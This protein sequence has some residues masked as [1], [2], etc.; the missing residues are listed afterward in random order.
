MN[1]LAKGAMSGDVPLK[2]LGSPTAARDL[3]EIL[4]V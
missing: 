2:R 4:S 1:S 3:R